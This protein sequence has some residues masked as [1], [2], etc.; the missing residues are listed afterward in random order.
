MDKWLFAW[1]ISL[2]GSLLRSDSQAQFHVGANFIEKV[3]LLR[4]FYEPALKIY[5]PDIVGS[6]SDISGKTVIV[7]VNVA[8][9]FNIECDNFGACQ[10]MKNRFGFLWLRTTSGTTAYWSTTCR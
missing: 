8:F 2:R 1:R 6:V 5:T 4:K 3:K 9:A 10:Q 7:F